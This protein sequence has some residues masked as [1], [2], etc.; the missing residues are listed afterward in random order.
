MTT[1]TSRTTTTM[2]IVR[3]ALAT[4]LAA[5]EVVGVGPRPT[6][7]AL[8]RFATPLFATSLPAVALRKERRQRAESLA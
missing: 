1:T 6:A 2:S 7:G 8:E 3:V 5:S 4:R